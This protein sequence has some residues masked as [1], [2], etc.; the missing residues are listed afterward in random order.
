V[1]LFDFEKLVEPGAS[2]V[3]DV[4][5]RAVHLWHEAWRRV[6]LEKDKQYHPRCLYEKLKR[7]FL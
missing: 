1:P 6:G 3:F 4:E 2:W 5:T 7:R